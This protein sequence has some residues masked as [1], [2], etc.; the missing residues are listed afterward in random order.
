MINRLKYIETKKKKSG[1]EDKNKEI[2]TTKKPSTHI[3]FPQ[4]FLN[5][6]IKKGKLKNGFYLIMR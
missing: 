1:T 6:W 3:D 5:Y 2:R 4:I